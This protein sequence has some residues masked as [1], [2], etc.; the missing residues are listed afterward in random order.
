MLSQ[1]ATAKAGRW[2]ADAQVDTSPRRYHWNP[3]NPTPQAHR[4]GPHPVTRA[5]SA[6]APPWPR[7]GMTEPMERPAVSRRPPP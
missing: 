3:H 4:R 6:A 1:R 5:T 7:D 2:P